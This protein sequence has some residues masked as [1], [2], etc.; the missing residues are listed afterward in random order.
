MNKK[1][2]VALM[3]VMVILGSAGAMAAVTFGEPTFTGDTDGSVEVTNET[4]TVYN[5]TTDNVTVTQPLGYTNNTTSANVTV[6]IAEPAV[7]GVTFGDQVS[8]AQSTTSNGTIT[9]ELEVTNDTENVTVNL[10]LNDSLV[11]F[12]QVNDTYYAESGNNSTASYDLFVASG[13]DGTTATAIGNFPVPDFFQNFG[14]LGVLAFYAIIVGVIILGGAGLYLLSQ[15]PMSRAKKT[16]GYAAI[17]LG[18]LGG[19]FDAFQGESGI[20]L[21]SVAALLLGAV[22]Y[23]YTKTSKTSTISGGTQYI[24]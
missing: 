19:V 2:I 21:V 6:Q 8:G 22:V 12:D 3:S 15:R 13:G 4:V 9:Y 11:A 7:D 23:L 20:I 18:S 1:L 17:S 10:D 5:G 14:D 24:E 16:G